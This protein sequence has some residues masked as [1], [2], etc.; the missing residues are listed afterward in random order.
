MPKSEH[1]L[2]PRSIRFTASQLQRL[3]HLRGEL[4]LSAYVI[5]RLFDE[6]Y[7]AKTRYKNPI[8]DHIPLAE[9]LAW[10]GRIYQCLKTIAEAV[11]NGTDIVSEETEQKIRQACDDIRLIR[12][13]VFKALGLKVE[14]KE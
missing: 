14:D 3:D 5:Q 2:F 1:K 4:S 9:I 11:K 10:L 8:K 7:S 6:K 12:N 13:A